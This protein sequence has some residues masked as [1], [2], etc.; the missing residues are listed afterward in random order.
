MSEKEK[1]IKEFVKE[2]LNQVKKSLEEYEK[3]GGDA[4]L[5]KDTDVIWELAGWWAMDNICSQLLDILNE[6][7]LISSPWTILK[8]DEH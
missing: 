7:E 5:E 1:K 3:K 6:D 8:K 2:N 4:D